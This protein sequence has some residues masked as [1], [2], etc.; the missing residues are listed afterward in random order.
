MVAHRKPD[1][2]LRPLGRPSVGL[3]YP[4]TVIHRQATAFPLLDRYRDVLPSFN[5]DIQGT[6]AVV[7]AGLLAACRAT[8]AKIEARKVTDGM[9]ADAAEARA[10]LVPECDLGRGALDP[11]IEDLLA[12]TRTLAAAVARAARDEAVGKPLGDH[13]IEGALDD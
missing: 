9:F 3:R 4:I 5:E 11:P 12:A 7:G 1:T 8:G 10:A 13:A 6:G 2:L